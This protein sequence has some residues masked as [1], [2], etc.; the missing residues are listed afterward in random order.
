M[1]LKKHE[2][3]AYR[4]ADILIRLNDGERLDITELANSYQVST[5]TLKR[6]FQDRLI[7]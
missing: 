1:G 2:K 4:L 6:D 3:L 7:F 5:R